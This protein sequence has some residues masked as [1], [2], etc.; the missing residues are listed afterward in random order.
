MLAT[1]AV[2]TVFGA[3]APALA[4]QSAGHAIV[5]Q[6]AAYLLAR[7]GIDFMGPAA[8]ALGYYNIVPDSLWKKDAATAE[9]ELPEHWIDLGQFPDSLGSTPWHAER[10]RYLREGTRDAAA[11]FPAG[12][13]PWRIAEL[14]RRLQQLAV[15]LGRPP[16]PAQHRADQDRWLV[17]A[18]LLGHYVAD[19]GM[20]LHVT[21]N[22]DG[23]LTGQP[24]LHS[25]IEGSVVNALMPELAVA[26]FAEAQRRWPA[27]A[28]RHRD[29]DA[30]ALALDLGR[31]SLAELPLLLRLDREVRR[32]DVAAASA[33]LRA[34]VIDRLAT[35]SLYLAAIWH[36]RL[37]WKGADGW[38]E[39][40]PAPRFIEPG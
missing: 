16:N 6:T 26:V 19:L 29:S 9:R 34:H 23:Q 1:L 30:F 39:I 15:S 3:P 36:R 21:A 14:D 28:A 4:W 13:A 11:T 18:G 12:A 40:V 33:H 31:D 27:F 2:A 5:G 22:H 32:A 38:H 25:F 20:P 35:A 17:T 7:D 37:G 10:R 8:I 24:G